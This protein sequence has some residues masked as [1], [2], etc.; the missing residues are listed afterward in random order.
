[1][2]LT[3]SCTLEFARAR[4]HFG[5][6]FERS[7]SPNKIADRWTLMRLQLFQ[8]RMS[9]RSKILFAITQ[10]ETGAVL[11]NDACELQMRFGRLARAGDGPANAGVARP[12]CLPVERLSIVGWNK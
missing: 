11:L 6:H 1:M 8:F 7:V 12:L 5:E 3:C 10:H 9:L 4:Q 2:S